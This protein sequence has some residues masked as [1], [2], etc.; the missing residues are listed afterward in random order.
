V[1]AH[2]LDANTQAGHIALVGIALF[3]ANQQI[4]YWIPIQ[5]NPI[6]DEPLELCLN[7]LQAQWSAELE[8]MAQM[9]A[10]YFQGQDIEYVLRMRYQGNML[11][12]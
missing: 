2:D 5:L 11:S 4:E 8:V 1:A 12:I 10:Q 9:I 3:H 7:Q 6:A